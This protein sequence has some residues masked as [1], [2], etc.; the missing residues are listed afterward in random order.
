MLL[1]KNIKF[2]VT[3]DEKRRIL[4]NC[5][6]LVDKGKIKK[7]EK[8]IKV[9][10][11]VKVFDCQKGI[12]LPALFNLHTHL[13]MTLFRGFKDHLPLHQWLK[14]IWKKE[15]KL[16][17]QD[18]K[19]GSE[20][21]IKELLSNGTAGFLD[22]YFF[23]KETA[24]IAKK[25]KIKAMLGEPVISI[26]PIKLD[27]IIKETKNLCEEYKN[28]SFIKI[29]L[30]PHSIYTVSKNDLIKVKNFAKKNNLFFHLH[31]SETEKEVKECQRIYKKR[32]VEFLDEIGILDE[33]TILAHVIWVTEK[34]VK[35]LKKRK[36]K[37]VSC[38][39][40]NLKLASGIFNFPLFKKYKIKICLGT[41]GPASNNSLNMFEEMKVFSLLQKGFFKN[42]TLAQAQEVLDMATINGGEIFGKTGR[43]K[44]GYSADFVLLS[45]K[46]FSFFPLKK[47]RLLSH[48]V[49]SKPEVLATIVEGEISFSKN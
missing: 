44:K 31:L 41:D 29:C 11:K 36:V 42:P 20:I 26:L 28:D 23:P 16:T 40:S 49:F 25:I 15:V 21:G 35:I 18:I 48:I 7:I 9:S 14:E 19:T 32:P 6:V 30:N 27:E 5:D 37:V 43:I 8:N 1:L 3:Q 10:Q 17:P 24:K 12:L 46:N 45:S 22:M 34:E 39:Q 2:I 47:E 4:E 13:S 33:K 38:P